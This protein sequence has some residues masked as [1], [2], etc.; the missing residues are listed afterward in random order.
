[1]RMEFGVVAALCLTAQLAQAADCATV[2]EKTASERHLTNIGNGETHAHFRDGPQ[3]QVSVGCELG[4]PNVQV[5][6]DG[7]SPDK[8]FYDLVG[9]LGQAVSG[10]K[11]SQV[12]QAAKSCRQQ[13]LQDG[14]E[15]GQVEQ[16][17]LAV[18]CQAF[19]RDGGGTTISV[20]AD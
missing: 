9:R 12:V 16:P 1:M 14:G 3:I 13:A 19:S 7:G 2:L 4:K 8:A 18:E 10:S 5:S 20:Y 6:W 11:P 15:I 17:G